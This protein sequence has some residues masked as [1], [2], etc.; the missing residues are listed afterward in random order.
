MTVDDLL[1]QLEFE[2][3]E[4]EHRLLKCKSNYEDCLKY[5]GLGSINFSY[6]SYEKAFG[7]CERLRSAIAVIKERVAT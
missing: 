1:Q 3:E 5:E 2:L 7:E 6:G 4:A